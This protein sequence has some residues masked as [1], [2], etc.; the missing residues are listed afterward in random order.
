M[1]RLALMLLSGIAFVLAGLIAIGNPALTGILLMVLIAF[2]L[3][4]NGGRTLLALYNLRGTPEL[5]AYPQPVLT[6]A[7]LRAAVNVALGVILVAL[8]PSL[9]LADLVALA[10]WWVI[11]T[12]ALLPLTVA[13]FLWLAGGYT[14]PLI[15]CQV[16]FGLI[17]GGLIV[18]LAEVIASVIKALAGLALIAF[19]LVQ[20]GAALAIWRM[21]GG[22]GMNNLPTRRDR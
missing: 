22:D 17:A 12:N 21:G 14:G 15:G 1:F 11:L 5:A 8:I 7:A 9:Q 3:I 4:S 6:V 16:Y 10:G 2:N 20:I 18:L 13:L 19:G